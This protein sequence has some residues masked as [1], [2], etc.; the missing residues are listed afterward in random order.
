MGRAGVGKSSLVNALR[1]I[2][3]EDDNAAPVHSWK[4]TEGA[5]KYTLRDGEY[6]WDIPGIMNPSKLFSLA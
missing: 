2:E 4:S 3:D 1:G 6:L 5:Q